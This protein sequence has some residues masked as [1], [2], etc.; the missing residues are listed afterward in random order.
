MTTVNACGNSLFSTT[1]TGAYV[2]SISPTLVTPNIGTPSA[3]NLANCTNLPIGSI[4]GLGTGVATALA[5]NVTGSGGIVLATSPTLVTPALGTPAS[6]TLT[7]CSGLPISGIASLG[8]GVASALAA[9]VTGSGGIV[10]AT[11]ATLVTP[12]SLGVQ[13][14][15]LNMNSYQINNVSDPTSAQDAAT[16]NY[17]DTTALGGFSVYAASAASLGT[18]TQS[19]AGP[20]ATLTNAGAQ[21]VFALDGVNPPVGSNVLIK[22]T[23]TGATAANEGIYTVTNAGSIITNW[24]LTRSTDYETP[25]QINSTGLIVVDNGNTLVGT[26]WYN[27]ATITTV[28]TTNFSY[29]RFGTSGTVTSIATSNGVTGGTITSSGTI[30]LASSFSINGSAPSSS[31]VMASDGDIA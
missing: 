19:G 29:S 21:A 4:A 26:A 27:T 2:G 11:G 24:V 3:G 8:T 9:N 23:S 10:L 16:K 7:N 22:N 6:G 18:V 20:G 17:V 15:A 1:G 28:D 13:Q 14:A 12:A 31:F 5:A 25:A 30:S